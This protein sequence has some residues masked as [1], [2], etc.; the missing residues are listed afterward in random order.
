MMQ[1]LALRRT[2]LLLLIGLAMP[3]AAQQAS[4]PRFFWEE[5]IQGDTEHP[6]RWPV[7][8]ACANETEVAVAD[9]HDPRLLVFRK[10]R[11]IG[12]WK[13]W[14]SIPLPAAPAEVVFDGR[15]YILA[16][17]KPGD[18]M[19]IEG[20]S[21]SQSTLAL[22]PGV[23][24]QAL[25]PTT[26]G[27]LLLYD[28]T[29][30]RILQL[31]AKGAIQREIA[32]VE[33]VSGLAL[34]ERG[35]ILAAFA[36]PPSVQEFG[37]DNQLAREWPVPGVEPEPAWP[38]DLVANG[39]GGFVVADRQGGRL[40]AFDAQGEVEGFGSRKGWDAPLLLRPV[41]TSRCSERKIAVADLGNGRV[42]LFRQ[43]APD[44]P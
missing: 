13:V 43:V 29:G 8:V 32:E 11:E 44:S 20:D 37:A 42:G 38:S 3:V 16:L 5:N 10:N 27:G 26:D 6:L 12:R 36:H 41:S 25:S 19:V 21:A 7:A 9:A 30:A 2:G 15:R 31:D 39:S 4:S 18:L 24:A 34:K 23:F 14:Q 33:L 28:G 17:R 22:P 1:V 35:S 40:I